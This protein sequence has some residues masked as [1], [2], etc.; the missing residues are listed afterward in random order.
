MSWIAGL[1]PAEDAGIESHLYVAS[2]APDARPDHIERLTELGFSH[3]VVMD[4]YVS[5]C[6]RAAPGR[7]AS[8]GRGGDTGLIGQ[9][10]LR[11]RSPWCGGARRGGCGWRGWSNKQGLPRVCV[12]LLVGSVAT[13]DIDSPHRPRWPPTSGAIALRATA[14]GGGAGSGCILNRG[15]Y[16]FAPRSLVWAGWP[17]PAR[18]AR[19]GQAGMRLADDARPPAAQVFLFRKRCWCVAT[20]TNGLRQRRH[21]RRFADMALFFSASSALTSAHARADRLRLLVHAGRARAEV[22][23]AG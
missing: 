17:G 5:S 10:Y 3:T 8:E 11:L 1:G 14:R 7:R 2:Y 13:T 12:D 9:R 23:H 16:R 18:C 22:A 15:A 19:L 4:A 6:R 21:A 20:D